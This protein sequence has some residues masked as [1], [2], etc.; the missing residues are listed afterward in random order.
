ML[1]GM[2]VSKRQTF[3]LSGNVLKQGSEISV[4]CGDSIITLISH[5]LVK[6]IK[7]FSIT[8]LTTPG[9]IVS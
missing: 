8:E 5:K 4:I 1:A 3:C 7:D 9:F 6:G 2:C